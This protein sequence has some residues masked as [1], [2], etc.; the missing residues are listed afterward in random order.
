MSDATG[1]LVGMGVSVS[2]GDGAIDIGTT[3]ESVVGT[4][5]TL[6]EAP[7]TSGV[8]TELSFVGIELTSGVTSNDDGKT[9]EITELT[10][11]PLLLLPKPHWY[12]WRNI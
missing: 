4:T 1:I 3:V 2:G 5:V 9:I 12:G 7:A 8:G 6:S 11:D 10:P